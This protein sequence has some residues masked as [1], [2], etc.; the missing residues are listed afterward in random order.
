MQKF[1][2]ENIYYLR[3]LSPKIWKIEPIGF[4][5]N[6]LDVKSRNKILEI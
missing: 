2:C 1:L 5:I 4:H 6:I 3:Y